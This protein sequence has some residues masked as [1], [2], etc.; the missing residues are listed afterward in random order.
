[1]RPRIAC[2]V[3]AAL[4][5][6]VAASTELATF[7]RRAPRWVK[8]RWSKLVCAFP[9]PNPTRE[10]AAVGSTPMRWSLCEICFR[11]LFAPKTH[12]RQNVVRS[13]KDH[14]ANKNI[15]RKI[16]LTYLACLLQPLAHAQ[17]Q[18]EVLEAA[19]ACQRVPELS[20]RLACYDR[21]F[22]PIVES[23]DAGASPAVAEEAP[24]ATA[25]EIEP[26]LPAIVQIVEVQMPD[27]RTTRFR[28]AD[29]RVFVRTDTT[30]LP[31]WPNTPFEVEFQTG[32]LGSTFLRFRESGLRIRVVVVD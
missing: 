25:A 15:G 9:G 21:V 27:L 17:T 19:R 12:H 3:G 16:T 30:T 7:C 24:A 13:M 23:I 1:M 29:G 4:S 31:R 14:H 32:I 2:V 8:Q 22:P 11:L 6:N 20:Y 18:T 5:A 28:A 10:R 26:A